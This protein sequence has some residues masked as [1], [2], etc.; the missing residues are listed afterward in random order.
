VFGTLKPVSI[1]EA[2]EDPVYGKDREFVEMM[3][4]S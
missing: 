3:I 1:K 4:D 2:I